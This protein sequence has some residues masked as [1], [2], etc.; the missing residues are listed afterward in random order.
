MILKIMENNELL[1]KIT[2]I[3]NKIKNNESFEILT[4]NKG[5]V[6]EDFIDE[7]FGKELVNQYQYLGWVKEEEKEIQS[8]NLRLFNKHGSFVLAK[9]IN[10]EC[11]GGDCGC[12]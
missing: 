9:I 3:I 2:E 8:E 1:Q 7:T 10:K 11:C 4:F 6:S 5:E 12:H